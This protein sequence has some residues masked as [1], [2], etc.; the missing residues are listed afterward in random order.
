MVFYNPRPLVRYEYLGH[1]TSLPPDL[2]LLPPDG[3]ALPRCGD[4]IQ[5]DQYPYEPYTFKAEVVGVVWD[6]SELVVTIQLRA[7]QDKG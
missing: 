4:Y 2:P 5:V 1:E 7:L 6:Y 3:W